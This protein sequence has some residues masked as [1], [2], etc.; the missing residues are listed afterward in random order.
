MKQDLDHLMDEHGL[1]ALV[2]SG[3]MHGNSA[4]YYMV[5]GAGIS[6][7]HVIKQRGQEP[8]LVCS[9]IEREL[10]AAS[11]LATVNM[12]KYDYVGILR[13]K[14]DRLAAT[15]EL[16]RRMFADLGVSGRVGF[17]GMGD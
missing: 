8:V 13:E 3:A 1:D 14:G 7:G 10:A 6:G 12:I 15:V 5:N 11:G 17:Y 9:P 16:Y 2:V 4:M